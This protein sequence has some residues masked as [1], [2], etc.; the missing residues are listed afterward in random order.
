MA[1]DDD[2]RNRAIITILSIFFINFQNRNPQQHTNMAMTLKSFCEFFEGTKAYT[3]EIDL[4]YM[5]PIKY[6]IEKHPNHFSLKMKKRIDIKKTLANLDWIFYR[7]TSI[8]SKLN[9]EYTQDI[10]KSIASRKMVL[11]AEIIDILG[12]IKGDLYKILVDVSVA[13]RVDLSIDMPILPPNVIAQAGI[14][15]ATTKK[16]Y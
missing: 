8:T 5:N 1:D 7:D 13:N 9:K 12:L 3:K 15:D 4:M 11:L 6:I 16:N 14:Q 10:M 2:I